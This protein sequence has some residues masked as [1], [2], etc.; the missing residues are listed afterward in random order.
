MTPQ[1]L[2]YPMTAAKQISARFVESSSSDV[3]IREGAVA[4]S[5]FFQVTQLPQSDEKLYMLMIISSWF[6]DCVKA[7]NS[8]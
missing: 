5:C 6:F 4:L 2:L 1:A 8:G 7:S 3:E